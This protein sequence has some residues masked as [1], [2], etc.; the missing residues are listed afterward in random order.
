MSE[1]IVRERIIQMDWVCRFCKHRNPGLSG[2]D[3]GMTCAGCGHPKDVEEY[4]MPGDTSAAATVT[5]PSL[6]SLALAGENRSCPVCGAEMRAGKMA[7]RRC[8]HGDEP[9]A[10]GRREE[11]PSIVLARP[12]PFRSEPTPRPPVP[13][14]RTMIPVFVV[15]A[16]LS[17][18]FAFM[19]WY[20]GPH[21]TVAEVTA[22]SWRTVEQLEQRTIHHTSGWDAPPGD[23]F[24]LECEQRQYG[25]E[26]CRPHDCNCRKVP[27]E[28]NCTGGDTYD[29]NPR[30]VP[31][32]CNCTGGD[33]YD[34]NPRQVPY[35]CNCTGGDTYD[36]NPRQVP[37]K[38][39]CTGGDTYECRCKD[40]ETCVPLKNGAAR[41]TTRRTCETCTHPRTCETC[42]KT[43]YET[44]TR[45]RTCET[46]TK[47]RYE[48]CTRP[49]TC[50]TCTKTEYDRCVHPR[51]CQTCMET[52]CDT[53]YD[54]CPVYRR[55]C[56]YDRATWHIVRSE[57][58]S[59]DDLEPRWFGLEAKGADQRVTRDRTEYTV[60]LTAGDRTWT[61]RPESVE[62]F[63]AYPLG[64]KYNVEYTYGGERRV[65]DV[66]R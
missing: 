7:C 43:Q 39:N 46:C 37:Y 3:Q 60:T 38:C 63:Q 31:Y 45:P 35:E 66:A 32:E 6:L 33:T 53:C 13:T 8:G 22:V 29:C 27:R 26:R 11:Q 40:T 24:N 18:G 1:T 51:K 34:C 30:Q 55:W 42:T 44:C 57:A 36:C 50:E 10:A 17:L 25:T 23:A 54:A 52:E 59:G 48:T 4:L 62:S 58:S 21:T 49:R 28:C 15:L 20:R 14:V 16:V 5:D 2:E 64:E 12:R 61:V 9:R 47:T 56:A 19:L 65:L 41:C